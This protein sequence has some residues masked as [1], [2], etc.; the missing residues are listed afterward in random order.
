MVQQAQM[1]YEAQMFLELFLEFI[2][3]VFI[4]VL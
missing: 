2:N 1:A 4:F 3:I